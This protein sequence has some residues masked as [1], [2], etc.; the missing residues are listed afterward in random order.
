M[1][2]FFRSWKRKLGLAA[3][4]TA[5]VF[6]A[7]WVRSAT[8]HE[9]ACLPIG[10]HRFIAIASDAGLFV[11]APTFMKNVDAFGLLGWREFPK[12]DSLRDD[13]D[14]FQWYFRISGV[15]VGRLAELPEGTQHLVTMVPYWSI[16]V[17]L[18]SL[19]A[20]LLLSKPRTAKRAEPPITTTN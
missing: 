8:I 17:P 18:T 7:G 4:L 9:E 5:S 1:R 19:S 2:E 3:L 13:L 15:A 14:E 12:G 10:R 16:V 6:M 20:W 11:I